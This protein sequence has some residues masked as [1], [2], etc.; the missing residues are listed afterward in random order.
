MD[1]RRGRS[2]VVSSSLS[3]HSTGCEPRPA[4]IAVAVSRQLVS[5]AIAR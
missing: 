1:L 5:V 3:I 4:A 2:T